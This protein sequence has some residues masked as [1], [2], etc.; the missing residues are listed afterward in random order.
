MKKQ[1]DTLKT[2]KKIKKDCDELEKNGDLT[3]YGN[4]QLALVNII[5]RGLETEDF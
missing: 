5:S 2:I 4:G 1:S 3:E